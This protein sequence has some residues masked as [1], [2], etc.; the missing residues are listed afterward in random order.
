MSASVCSPGHCCT[1]RSSPQLMLFVSLSR[2]SW[3][4]CET[5]NDDKGSPLNRSR[6]WRILRFQNTAQ[7]FVS[8]NS[9]NYFIFCHADHEVN[10]RNMLF[11]LQ[12]NP[13][14]MCACKY[15]I[16]H[17]AGP[18]WMTSHCVAEKLV[19]GSSSL[20]DRPHSNEWGCCISSLAEVGLTRPKPD[21]EHYVVM[22]KC[23]I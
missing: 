15:L 9:S 17:T 23:N 19:P 6:V 14:G 16:G 18:Y 7:G 4:A 12:S 11:M 22:T 21:N 5:L 20:P 8:Y 1:E 2:F 13:P 10:G 3:A